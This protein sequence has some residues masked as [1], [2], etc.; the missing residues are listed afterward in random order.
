[1]KSLSLKLDDAIFE[2]TEKLTEQMKL[3]RNRYINEAISIYNLYNRR[4]LL[5]K[6][7]RKESK[8]TET[9]S[10]SILKEFEKIVDGL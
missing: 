3:A 6:Q 7:L 8:L 4:K 2:E 9:E 10:L 5:K 1:M